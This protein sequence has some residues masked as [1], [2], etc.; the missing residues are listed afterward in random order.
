M[1][2]GINAKVGR[3]SARASCPGLRNRVV[4]YRPTLKKSLATSFRP[5]FRLFSGGRRW[6]SPRQ[7]ES[8]DWSLCS[9]VDRAGASRS[10]LLFARFLR[11]HEVVRAEE[12]DSR[13]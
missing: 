4:K 12:R 7:A 3:S 10:R 6:Y 13:D 2:A 8:M 1:S 5:T 11:G 9:A